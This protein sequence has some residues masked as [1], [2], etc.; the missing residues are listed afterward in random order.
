MNNGA[1]LPVEKSSPTEIE[2]GRAT[3]CDLHGPRTLLR[4]CDLLLSRTCVAAC[5]ARDARGGVRQILAH[6]RKS[7]WTATVTPSDGTKRTPTPDGRPSFSRT[8]RTSAP[9]AI[10][11][12]WRGSAS[13]MVRRSPTRSCRSVA[14][15]NPPTPMFFELAANQ[16]SPAFTS[17]CISIDTRAGRT[18]NSRMV[19][20]NAGKLHGHGPGL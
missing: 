17:T 6:I 15:N 10:G 5:G 2:F 18:A 20:E 16:S 19:P 9:T 3:L 7:S 8:Q 4:S 14:M 11:R 12:M 13:S 1:P